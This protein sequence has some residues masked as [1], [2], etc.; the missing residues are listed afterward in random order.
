[1][2]KPYILL[3]SD[4]AEKLQKQVNQ[5]RKNGY[6]EQGGIAISVVETGDGS[7]EKPFKIISLFAQAMVKPD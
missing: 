5:K 3:T 1:M 4:E 7:Y 6:K 2:R